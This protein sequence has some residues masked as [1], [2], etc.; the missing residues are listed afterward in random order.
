MAGLDLAIQPFTAIAHRASR[1]AHRVTVSL[2]MGG[3][4]EGGHKGRP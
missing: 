1:I 2:E 4:L 3:R